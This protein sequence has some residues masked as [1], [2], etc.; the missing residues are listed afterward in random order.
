MS[1][2]DESLG[3]PPPSQPSIPSHTF[4]LPFCSHLSLL[5]DYPPQGPPTSG[6][7]FMP[8]PMG[9]YL[10]HT[11]LPSTSILPSLPLLDICFIPLTH[12]WSYCDLMLVLGT[13]GSH[14]TWGCI[15]CSY[16]VV[17]E[18]RECGVWSRHLHRPC[19]SQ[20][21]AVGGGKVTELSMCPGCHPVPG[22]RCLRDTCLGK[23]SGAQLQHVTEPPGSLYS[24]GN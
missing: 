7:T 5:R 3:D 17:P 4:S 14:G 23:E 10:W 18:Q 9:P 1:T 24:Q 22:S 20:N 11:L 13:G 16:L 15:S 6:T 21:R 8:H 2:L 19:L 12:L